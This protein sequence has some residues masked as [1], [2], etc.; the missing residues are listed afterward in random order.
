MLQS[1]FCWDQH[2]QMLEPALTMEAIFVSGEGY[3]RGRRATANWRCGGVASTLDSRDGVAGAG[4]ACAGASWGKEGSMQGRNGVNTET[5][6]S[7]QDLNWTVRTR[8]AERLDRRVGAY[9]R[10]ERK[11]LR[12]GAPA[13]LSAG[14]SATLAPASTKLPPCKACVRGCDA[15][16]S[17]CKC[18]NQQMLLLEPRMKEA[19]DG[20]AQDSMIRGNAGTSTFFCWNQ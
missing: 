7:S 1:V 10:P 11:M 2:R 8:P 15:G 16:A 20:G 9:Q 6:N 5:S 12:D 4:S 13:E 19:S 14:S 17:L 18:Y 3:L